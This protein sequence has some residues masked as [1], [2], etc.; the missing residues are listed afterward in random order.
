M[1]ALLLRAELP[2]KNDATSSHGVERERDSPRFRR[3]QSPAESLSSALIAR[4]GS[5]KNSRPEPPTLS[6][7]M[8]ARLI[9]WR[10]HSCYYSFAYV[11]SG[12][13][14]RLRL[15][16][17]STYFDPPSNYRQRAQQ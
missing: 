2:A 1:L 15:R 17:C 9:T 13:S 5:I 10:A 12:I 3:N 14:S 4:C 11:G 8:F 6:Y 7:P 16:K